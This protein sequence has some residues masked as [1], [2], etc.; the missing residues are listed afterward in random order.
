LQ[1]SRLAFLRNNVLV[2]TTTDRAAVEGTY[3]ASI[4]SAAAIYAD[5]TCLRLKLKLPVKGFEVLLLGSPT[6]LYILMP[7]STLTELQRKLQVVY[8]ATKIL[9]AAWKLYVIS[10]RMFDIC[11][12]Y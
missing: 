6:S 10:H 12:K 4:G 8:V 7:L 1:Q 5:Q 3:A 11:M 9:V 2:Q